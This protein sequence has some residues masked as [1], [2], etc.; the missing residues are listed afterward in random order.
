MNKK[1]YG[2]DLSAFSLVRVK[3]LSVKKFLIAGNLVYLPFKDLSFDVVHYKDSLEHIP[4]CFLETAVL[5]SIRVARKYVVFMLPLVRKNDEEKITSV[6][7][8]VEHY[9]SLTYQS[10]E[11]VFS[12]FNWERLDVRKRCK[13]GR[14]DGCFVYRKM[15]WVNEDKV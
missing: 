12:R 6:E 4:G 11:K 3:D 13:M 15:N 14:Y 2:V 7:S 10:W 8:F 1:V 9:I 5:E